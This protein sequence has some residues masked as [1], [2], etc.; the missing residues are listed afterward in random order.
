ML[1]DQIPRSKGVMHVP[2]DI[3]PEVADEDAAKAEVKG[4]EDNSA[5]TAAHRIMELKRLLHMTGPL[6]S[7]I[8]EAHAG[9][10]RL[11]VSAVVETLEFRNCKSI[12]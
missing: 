12:L 2:L 8:A 10:A 9:D 4:L 5:A 3:A 6:I 11:A 1:A 7:D